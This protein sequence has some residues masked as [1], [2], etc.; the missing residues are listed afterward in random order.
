VRWAGLERR[1][2]SQ[3]RERHEK[4]RTW[5][6]DRVSGYFSPCAKGRKGLKLFLGVEGSHRPGPRPILSHVSLIPS[7]DLLVRSYPCGRPPSLHSSHA[8]P[9]ADTSALP[10]DDEEH[11]HVPH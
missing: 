3:F 11:G 6:K 2:P 8:P 7:N 1:A 5:T 10:R 4:K 9:R